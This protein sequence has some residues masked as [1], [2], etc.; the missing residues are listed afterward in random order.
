MSR[1][2]TLGLALLLGAAPLT[3]QSWTSSDQTI[4]RIFAEGMDSSQ[5]YRLAQTLFD[6]IGPRLTGTPQIKSGNDW[7]VQMYTSWGVSARN[8]KYGTW[9]GWRR[10]ISHVD[11]LTPR[12]KSLEG[13]MLAWSPGTGGKDVAGSAVVLP[14]V[15]DSNAFVAWLPQVK[16]KFVLISFPEPTCRPDDDWQQWATK[17][18]FDR[19]KEQRS[20]ARATWVKRIASTGYTTGLAAGPLGKRLGEAGAAGIITSRWDNQAWGT[21]RVFGDLRQV[22]PAIELSCEDYGLVFRL[23]DNHQGPTLRVRAESEAMGD[24]PVFNTIA[25]L[26]GTEKPNEYVVLSAHFD[27]W[28]AGS[29]ATDN[30]T[31]TL[32]MMEAMRILKKI[33]P[34]PK[35]TIVVGHWSGEEQGLNG[36]RAWAQ[37]H[38]EVV[39]GL[40]ALFNQDNGTGRVINLSAS[41]LIG[42]SGFLARWMANV[43]TDIARHVQMSFPGA[44][45]GGGSDNASFACYGAP[46]FGL[47]A[48]GWNY[49]SYTW[50]TNRDT[51]DKVVFDELKNNATLTAILAYLASE[52]SVTVPRDR[53]VFEQGPH[54][55]A[56]GGFPQ[57]TSWPACTAP[58]RDTSGYTR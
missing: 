56:P 26:K 51:F 31:G 35:R 6:S 40:Q 16:G 29:G 41:G 4:R 48:I 30:G 43:P 38:P 52:D 10:G 39:S 14:E 23:A 36:S 54:A 49:G 3:A 25:E 13:G 22:V 17:E 50:H 33:Y 12:T 44:P 47:G 53:R 20:A 15:A 28:D 24:V 21:R 46:G 11:L 2:P 58:L 9:R 45:P 34:N 42:A 57:P 8:E 37:D 5:T 1:T 7:L 55:A 27:S 18:S 32:T 19:M